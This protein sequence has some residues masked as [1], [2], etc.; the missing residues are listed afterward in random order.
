MFEYQFDEE[1]KQH[2]VVFNGATY[3]LNAYDGMDRLN[4]DE[5]EELELVWRVTNV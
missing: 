5:I 4:K 1:T 3:Q 2:S